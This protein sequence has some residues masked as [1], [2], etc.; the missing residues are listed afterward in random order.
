MR[1]DHSEGEMGGRTIREGRKDH[2][3]EEEELWRGG[4]TNREGTKDH[5][6]GEE[7]RP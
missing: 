1:K 6:G 4:R 2:S 7:G 5:L 3:G